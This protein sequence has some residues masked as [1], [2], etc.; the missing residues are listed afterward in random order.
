MKP[1]WTN[2]RRN[3]PVTD[4]KFRTEDEHLAAENKEEVAK[5]HHGDKLA[6]DYRHEPGDDKNEQ[7]ERAT[8]P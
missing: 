7:E 1:S 8:A 3:E 2:E 4:R 6:P 5:S